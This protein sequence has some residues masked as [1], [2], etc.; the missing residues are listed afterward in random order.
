MKIL[1]ILLMAF[2]LVA[3]A[4]AV[5]GAEKIQ[6]VGGDFG[7]AW[8]DNYQAQNP[9][10]KAQDSEDNLSSWGGAPK[11]NASVSSN[12]LNQQTATNLLG[13]DWL[14]VTTPLGIENNTKNNSISGAMQENPFSM[15]KTFTP[16]YQIDASWNQTLQVPQLPQPDKNGLINGLPAETYYAIGPAYFD[17]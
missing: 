2:C 16:V 7:R 8:L 3:Y 4:Q 12:L 6:S 14:G 17:F 5:S 9:E 13:H 10:P 15:S 1:L 11:G